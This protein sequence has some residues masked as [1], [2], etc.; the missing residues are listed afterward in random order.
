MKTKTLRRRPEPRA[1][2]DRMESQF[3]EQ[4]AALAY[5]LW[6]A[7]GCPD[8]SPDEDW[9][10]AERVLVGEGKVTGR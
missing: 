2:E 7:R 5:A 10:H 4:V 9:Y 8:G 6:E 1:D 3:S